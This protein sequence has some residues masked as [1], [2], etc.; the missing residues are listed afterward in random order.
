MPHISS[1]FSSACIAFIKQW[2]GLSL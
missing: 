1:R 2:Q